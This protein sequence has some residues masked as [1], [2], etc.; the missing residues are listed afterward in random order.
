M[1]YEATGAMWKFIRSTPELEQSDVL[2]LLALADRMNTRTGLIN[3][4][5]SKLASDCHCSVATVQRALRRLR[6]T[7][8]LIRKSGGEGK[9][10]QYTL[11]A[12]NL[13]HGDHSQIDHSQDDQTTLVIM[14]TNPGHDD[15][16]PRSQCTTN[17]EV[18]SN[19]PAKPAVTITA[20]GDA[21]ASTLPDMS[22]EQRQ[23]NLNNIRSI[24]DQLAAKKRVT[25]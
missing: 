10:N 6:S 23:L 18:T 7:G 24:M 25:A 21:T 16:A 3:P 14:T 5:L 2:V 12:P 19:E 22:E 4:S 13:V 8:I 9:S 17:Q 1:S 11:M 15:H 20:S